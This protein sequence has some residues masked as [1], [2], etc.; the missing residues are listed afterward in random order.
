MINIHTIFIGLVSLVLISCSPG[1][2]INPDKSTKDK[3]SKLDKESKALIS[4]ANCLTSNQCHSIGFGHKPC[5]GFYSYRIYS[6]QGTD[7]A[8]LK[9]KINQYNILSKA[10]NKNNNII[11]NCMMLM[12]PQ[13][14][15]REK[16]CQIK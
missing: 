7:V 16:T 3:M 11:S 12:Q 4:S 10:H 8:I 14:A 2:T 5:G 1:S 6:D 9:N 13:L 15:C